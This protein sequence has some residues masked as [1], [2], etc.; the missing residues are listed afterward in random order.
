MARGAGWG[1]G[2][3]SVLAGFVEPGETLEAAVTREV[4]EEV[5]VEVA[6]V[7]FLGDQPWPFPTS[8][9]LGF[10]ARALGTELTLQDSE[11]ADARWFTRDELLAR[12]ASGE[13]FTSPRLSISRWL[14]EHWLGREITPPPVDVS[15]R[16]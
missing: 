10:T 4:R 9:M 2:R 1:E 12:V 8:I 7:R 14:V 15:R 5:G 6:E 3:Y 16:G 13:L 11:I